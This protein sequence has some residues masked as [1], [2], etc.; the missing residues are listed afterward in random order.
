MYKQFSFVALGF[1]LSWLLV[2]RP[3]FLL[4]LTRYSR[5]L[6][7]PI[8]LFSVLG[9]VSSSHGPRVK[10]YRWPA[11][12]YTSA[13][14]YCRAT[15]GAADLT[16]QPSMK[17]RLKNKLTCPKWQMTSR[18]LKVDALIR[19]KRR[20]GRMDRRCS[21]ECLEGGGTGSGMWLHLA[22]KVW[23]T[24]TARSRPSVPADSWHYGFH[25]FPYSPL[26]AVCILDY[27]TPLLAFMSFAPDE[28]LHKKAHKL[29]KLHISTLIKR[30]QEWWCL[31]IPLS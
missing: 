19:K 20:D 28:V 27:F 10:L 21:L 29:M 13:D 7:D 15:P 12:I 1:F 31:D 18:K 8:G 3:R 14:S 24:R 23:D 9:P 16:Q 5:R 2:S 30:E 6:L 25:F 4:R 22:I 11:T 26:F 17:H